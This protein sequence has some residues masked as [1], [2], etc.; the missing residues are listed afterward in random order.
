MAP[1]TTLPPT[2]PVFLPPQSDSGVLLTTYETMR[3]QRGDLLGVEWGY[4]VLDE[5]HKIRNPDA[6]VTLAA[7]QV[8]TVHRLI[9]SGSPIQNR[10]TELW[11]LFDFVF[12]GKLGTLP[13][14]TAQ[15][16][17]PIQIGGYANASPLQVST[18]YRCA[19][20]LRDLIAPYLLRRR[21]ADV[22]AQLPRKTEQV[23]RPRGF[24]G[25][26][27][28]HVPSSLAAAPGGQLAAAVTG[29]LPPASPC[30][31]VLFCGLTV[32]QRDLYRGYLGSKELR[33]IFSGSRTALAGIDV[34]RKICNHPDLLERA[35]WEAAEDYGNPERSGK[36]QVLAK[37]LRHW[38][39]QGHKALVF[40]QTQQMLDILEKHVEAQVGPAGGDVS[41][42][43]LPCRRPPR[44]TRLSTAPPGPTR[45]APVPAARPPAGLRLPPHGRQHQCGAARPPHRRLQ[46]QPWGWGQG[47]PP[48]W[49]RTLAPAPLFGACAARCCSG[50]RVGRGSPALAHAAQCFASC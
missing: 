13:V 29:A 39:E 8:Q 30:A 15:F 27:A 47:W 38:K 7:K 6:E 23:G 44:C 10:L 12:P 25:Q 40:T 28:P 45:P 22:R 14:F 26:G 5:G 16:A 35:K 33:E 50:D 34:L 31:Q 3:L 32:E 41:A 9:M 48:G 11:S 17:L 21:K 1:L 24:F 36:L 46:Q 19:V 20:I 2:L 37:V 43:V 4:V 18:A 49:L 42:A